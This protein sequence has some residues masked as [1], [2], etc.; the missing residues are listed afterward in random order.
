VIDVKYRSVR[1]GWCSLPPA[2]SYGVSVWKYVRRGWDTF[3]KHVR[4]EVGDGYHVRFWHDLWCGNRPLKLCY[5][6]VYTL[7]RFP[8][9]CVV[10]NLS[11]VDRVAHWNVVFMRYAQ[12]WE[13]KMVLS[14]HEQLYS[15][16]IQHEGVD[17]LVESFQEKEL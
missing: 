15:T 6:I 5:P 2:R 1:G 3:A 17:R 16:R 13:V 9:A 4:L 11:V 14:F 12:D 10:D 8:D 7:A